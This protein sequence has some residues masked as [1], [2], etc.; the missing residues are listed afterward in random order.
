MPAITRLLTLMS[1]HVSSYLQFEYISQY[2]YTGLQ[3]QSTS[4]ACICIA[5][6]LMCMIHTL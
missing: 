4:Q 6:N 1:Q 2:S 5:S 3:T